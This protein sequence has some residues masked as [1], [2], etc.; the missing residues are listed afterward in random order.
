MVEQCYAHAAETA[1]WTTRRR[2]SRR[3]RVPFAMILTP[4]DLPERS[5]RGRG[6]PV[7]DCTTTRSSAGCAC[8][9]HPTLFGGDAGGADAASS[10]A[11]G[12]HTDE[13]LAELGLGD[14]VAD[15]RAAGVVA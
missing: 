8:P 13:I 14:R 10:P 11:L 9:R 12:E 15:L 4:A 2:A 1:R 7:R 5:A 3:E 6:R